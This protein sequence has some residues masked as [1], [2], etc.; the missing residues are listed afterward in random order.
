MQGTLLTI[1]V[2]A[3]AA[4]ALAWWLDLFDKASRRRRGGS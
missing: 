2:L 3:V 4:A 1:L